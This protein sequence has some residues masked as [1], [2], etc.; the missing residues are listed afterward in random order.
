MNYLLRFFGPGVLVDQKVHSVAIR[1]RKQ[2]A[3]LVYLASEHQIAH[4]RET[5]LA[6]LWP[7]SPRS[8]AQNN[9]RFTLS[10][11]RSLGKK[12]ALGGLELP[13]ILVTDRY[14]V[15]LH[16][17]WV[18]NADSNH[19]QQLLEQTRRHDHNSRSQCEACQSSL[20]QAVQLYQGD[21]LV[22]FSLDNC[23]AFEEWLFMQREQ[24]YSQ[25][26]EAYQD[27]AAYAEAAEDLTDALDYV[28]RQ[29]ELAPLRESAYRQEMRILNRQG[30]RTSALATF[31]RCR[32][33]LN[34]ELGLDPEPETLALHMQIL[35]GDSASNAQ[36]ETNTSNTESPSTVSSV[37]HN[38]PYQL[39]QFIGR[40]DELAQMNQ[41]L[42]AGDSRLISLVGQGGIGKTRLALQI[43][44]ENMH[45][46]AHGV[47]FVPLA[48]VQHVG[49]IPAAIM[50]ALGLTFE[51]NATSSAQQLFTTL[52]NR[53]MM[54]VI[55]NFEH[56]IDGV[57]F[58]LELLQAAPKITLLVTTREQLNCQAE[59]LFELSGLAVPNQVDLA[60]AS[61]YA[62]VRLFCERAYRLHKKRFKLS[63]EN[64]P[65]VVQICQ[66][67]EGMPLAIELAT[68]WLGHFDCEGLAAAIAENQ[69]I[70][71]TTQRDLP[72]RHRSMQTVFEHSWQMLSAREQHILS[73]VAVCQGRFSGQIATQLTGAS[74]LDLT[75]LRYKSFLRIVD[76]G[77]YD[78]HPLIRSFAHSRLDMEG[79][80]Q[81]EER[82]TTLY[83]Q[84]V[85]EQRAALEGATPQEALLRIGRELD[86]VHQAWA[87]AV[88]HNR[89]DL[90]LQGVAGLGGYY[91]AVG[92]NIECE[93]R[94]LSLA[95]QL[96]AQ[97]EDTDG[98]GQILCAQ[99]LDKVCHSL[100]WLGKLT[101]A[102]EW[103]QKMV[104]LAQT[105]DNQEIV[106]RAFM[107]WGKVLDEMGRPTEAV[108]KYEEAL[109]P[110]R[111]LAHAPLIGNILIELSHALRILGKSSETESVL[112]E[113]LEIQRRQQG[114]RLTEQRALLYL[115][116]C[117][118]EEGDFQADRT[119]LTEAVDLLKVTG[120]RHVETRLLDALG[121]NYGLVGNYEMALEYHEASRRIAQE[122]RQ[123][124]QESHTLRHMCTAHRKLGNL[125]L[126]QE[127][128]SESLRVALAHGM[129][130]E[131]NC[132][133]L[134]LGL[135]WLES[136]NLAEAQNAFQLAHD[137]WQAQGAISQSHEALVGL[138]M[139]D[140]RSGHPAR[141]AERIAPLV[142][143]LMHRVTVGAREPY[144]MH[145]ACYEILS[146]VDDARAQTVLATIYNQLQTNVNKVTD[147]T[148]L[149]YF[150]Q[151]PAHRKIR[152]L[153]QQMIAP[154]SSV[155]ENMPSANR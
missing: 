8:S 132:A 153:W 47:C 73:Q 2:L 95:Q 37:L 125:A 94:F 58:L 44:A 25:V 29:I 75:S 114:N 86:N 1:S 89:T 64:Y 135:V 82:M 17:A 76:A 50:D 13:P 72:T 70:L 141:A 79:R 11:L 77:Y 12:L 61:Q 112:L 55:D 14:T 120:N 36:T 91:N 3:L 103:A 155:G 145:L 109:A 99:L 107:H 134:Y 41:W 21:F 143:T 148:L 16:P 131:T 106:A 100:L 66:L 84:Q 130:D 74:L 15:Q 146:A 151:A 10:H 20:H 105:V 60:E 127:C 81:T 43:A 51:S 5:L 104:D 101:D 23:A 149:E 63:D 88:N 68:T 35:A 4:S 97:P 87:W 6:L 90:L 147:R 138:A 34:K 9:L 142:P 57:E 69:L 115:S 113:S 80:R 136:G 48:G 121:I 129:P 54:L 119:Y 71:A 30:E 45:L 126:A 111:Q 49:A 98:T 83:M 144:E 123:P 39:T 78:L 7:D 62:A 118:R 93:T 38:L 65:A 137:S 96:M 19:F 85:E 53:H 133:R 150:W 56:L 92:R 26:C 108:Q 24:Y 18:L 22:G 128:G 102:Q 40:E 140:L 28:Q 42:Q 139:V 152:E 67:V 154:A 27:L 110:A 117:K 122:I 46:F 33:L 124:V 116:V 59:D 52:A 32:T 31:E